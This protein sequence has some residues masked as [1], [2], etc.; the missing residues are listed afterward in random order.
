MTLLGARFMVAVVTIGLALVV[1]RDALRIGRKDL[2]YIAL[3]G[4]FGVGFNS[5]LY[6][7]SL[8]L[9]DASLF[10]ALLYSYPSM[11]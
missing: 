11:A 10:A 9:V 6:F 3:V 7:Y 4:P 8:Q 1:D 2:V 5:I